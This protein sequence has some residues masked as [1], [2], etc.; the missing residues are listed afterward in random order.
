MEDKIAVIRIKLKDTH[1]PIRR[2]VEVDPDITL[3]E[4]HEIIQIVMGWENDHLHHFVADGITYDPLLAEEYTIPEELKGIVKPEKPTI[5]TKL[6]DVLESKKFLYE[7]DFGDSWEHE[8]VFNRYIEPKKGVRYPICAAAKGLCP[9]EDIGG[10]GRYNDLIYEAKNK[11][12][13]YSEMFLDKTY[14]F[15]L[16]VEKLR[17]IENEPVDIKYINERLERFR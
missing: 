4:F 3:D 16:S 15:D 5:T 6:R 14:H 11:T 17:N 1:Y 9:P 7:Y 13:D 12:G 2:R 10:I 8:I